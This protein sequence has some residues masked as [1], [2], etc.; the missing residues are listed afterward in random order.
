V[1]CEG[2]TDTLTALAAGLPAVGVPGVGHAQGSF[3]KAFGMLYEDARR[4]VVAFDNDEAGEKAAH[5][6]QVRFPQARRL[7]FPGGVTDL[8][9]WWLR[10]RQELTGKLRE[11]VE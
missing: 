2:E 5:V 6:L 8:N 9:D 1:L 10:A 3:S 11:L 4:I 7:A